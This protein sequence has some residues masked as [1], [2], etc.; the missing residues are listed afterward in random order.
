[1]S[2]HE[3]NIKKEFEAAEGIEDTKAEVVKK[4]D[5]TI[6]NLG[7]VDPLKGRGITSPDDPEIKRIKELSGYIKVELGNLPSAGRFYR[8]DF[9]IHIRAARVGEIRDF[10]MMDENNIKDVDAQRNSVIVGC[11]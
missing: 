6:S 8:E 11:T 7:K 1:M 9:E 2:K 4:E 10:S 3:E 5:G